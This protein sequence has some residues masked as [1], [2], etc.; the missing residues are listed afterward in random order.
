MRDDAETD[1][2]SVYAYGAVL[3]EP[4]ADLEVVHIACVVDLPAADVPWGV[5]PPWCS[6]LAYLLE[7]E[8]APVVWRWRSAEWPVWNHAIRRP[9]AVWTVDG[10]HGEALDALAGR[11][12]D[13][14]RL[15][16]PD[17]AE[18]AEQAEREL[19]V[20][21]A[22]L[23]SVRDRYW[24]DRGWRREHRGNGRYPEHHLWDAVDGYL[25]LLDAGGR[26]D[27]PVV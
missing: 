22:H 25:D 5:E 26:E 1:L 20:S 7:L 23:R 21:A 14:F 15:A 11:R 19:A 12:A 4:G 10:V 8:K 27:G 18:R 17:V 16:E 24:D 13:S 2:V 3:D 6:S 9:M